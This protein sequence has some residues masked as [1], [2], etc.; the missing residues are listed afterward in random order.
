[1]QIPIIEKT[2]R[3]KSQAGGEK[4]KGVYLPHKDKRGVTKGIN[5]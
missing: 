1:L 4:E 3:V 5:G 2:F